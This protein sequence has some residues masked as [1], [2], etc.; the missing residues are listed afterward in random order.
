MAKAN[1]PKT[2]PKGNYRPEC[3]VRANGAAGP[4]LLALHL[5]NAAATRLSKGEPKGAEVQLVA[6]S[7]GFGL[8][9]GLIGT[10][11]GTFLLHP[12]QH[13][14]VLSDDCGVARATVTAPFLEH[15]VSI[16]GQPSPSSPLS[17]TRQIKAFPRPRTYT[18]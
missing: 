18:G 13:R 3:L 7:P 8:V 10:S 5:S 4:G 12:K 2:F 15:V 9:D 6:P 17:A 14:L 1:W 11:E 16:A